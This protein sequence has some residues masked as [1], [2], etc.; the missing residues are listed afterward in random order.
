[1]KENTCCFTGHR[2]ISDT[3]IPQVAADLED[4]IIGLIHKG[5][6]NF[7]AGGALGFDTLAAQV[8]I[9]VRDRFPDIHLILILPCRNQA[10][11]WSLRDRRMYDYIRGSANDVIYTS[12]EYTRGC[13]YERNRRLVN[14]SSFCICYLTRTSGGTVYT[15]NYAK[16]NGIQIIN[17]AK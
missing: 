13:M 3:L 2:E 16:N 17:L 12:E 5:Y 11:N 8:V 1:M 15:V 10:K 6:E 4:L 7:E 14:D 9:R